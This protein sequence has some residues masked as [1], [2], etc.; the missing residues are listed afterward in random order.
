MNQKS[1]RRTHSGFNIDP[2]IIF[3]GIIYLVTGI[4]IVRLF[5]LQVIKHDFYQ[6][7]AAR[8]HNQSS[9]LPAHRGEIFI[10][11]YAANEKVRVATNTTLD[12]LFADPAI[13]KDKKIVAN[14][15]APLIF[16]LEEA[17]EQD[18]VRIKRDQLRSQTIEEY[19]KIKP[20]KD[21][22]L[23]KS[24][25][26]EIL[27]KLSQDI[28]PTILLADT[29]D[30]NTLNYIA[31]L[32]INGTEIKN[33]QLYAYPLQIQDRKGTATQLSEFLNRPPA[34]LER[35][36]KGVNHYVVLKEKI[37]PEISAQI[38]KTI[39]EDQGKN[40][41]GLGL[42]EKYFRFYPEGKLA[43]N[44]LGFVN[45][46][47]IGSYGI[48]SKFNTE[49][50]GKNGIFQG[51][52]DAGGRQITVGETVIQPAVDG[53]N[54]TLTIDRSIQMHVEQQVQKA[55]KDYRADSGQVIIMNPKTGNI[56]AMAHFPTFDPNQYG[57]IYEK[58]EINLTADQK[59]NL[60]SIEGK[61]NEFWLYYNVVAHDRTLVFKE[62]LTDGTEIYEKYKNNV[63]A[64]AYQNKIV[65]E[66]YEPGSVFKVIAMAIGI[67]DKDVTPTTTI[68]DPGF[69]EIELRPGVKK[70]IR[71][72]SEK[73]T[74]RVTMTDVLGN[75]CNTGMAYVAKEMGRNL[76]YNYMKKFGLGER[77]EIEFDNENAGKIPAGQW[78]ESELYTYAFGQGL[79]V[80]PIQMVTAISAIANNGVMM[81]PHIIESIEKEPGKIITT[82]PSILGQVIS[83]ET[84]KQ[85]TAMMV[86][87]VENGVA[88]GAALSNHYIA[89]KTGTAQTYKNGVPLSGAG[90]TITSVGGFGPIEN[91][92]WVMLVKLD[93]PRSSEWSEG[94]AS[95]L[96]KNIASF[97]YEYYSTPPDKK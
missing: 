55:V 39:A 6:A 37:K 96:Y 42:T 48:E 3:L 35:V 8:A 27:A 9:K 38:K 53:A 58:E 97:L 90:T 45:G 33:N 36:L 25:Y 46:Q 73:C 84:A 70:Q 85:I 41:S 83:P 87:A 80:T 56:I 63:G 74:G 60:V 79:T 49:L 18:L 11:D 30:E 68:N 89:A 77:T 71:N 28:R 21:D 13:I 94:T 50:S 10:K 67:D 40:F 15:I 72:V 86:N 12:T 47:S 59:K 51:Q 92:Q 81:Q 44:I 2:G 88:K 20:L 29:L 5:Y 16:N 64:E 82:Q 69:V 32:K 17:R 93:R 34:E 43:A 22:E 26:D 31:N 52:K 23:Y 65:S 76:F 78:A 66:P 54:I 75:S 91:P 62:T 57:K 7:E 14:R 61:T 1:T 95:V 19:N 24:F 4:I